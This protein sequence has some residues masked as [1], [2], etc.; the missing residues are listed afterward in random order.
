MLGELMMT[1]KQS[2]IC[3]IAIIGV[4]TG[5]HSSA[6]TRSGSAPRIVLIGGA[7]SHEAG[8]HDFPNGIRMLARFLQSSPSVSECRVLIDSYPDGWPT[9]ADAF[10]N[11]STIVWYFDGLE[12]HPLFDKRRRADFT[13]LMR[14]GVGLVALH[15]SF[16]VP[17]GARTIQLSQWLGGVRYGMFD[18]TTEFVQFGLAPR[19]PITRGVH[20]L[21]YR[22]EFYPTISF[23]DAARRIPILS[24]PLH[25]QYRAGRVIENSPAE[26]Y[27]VAWAFERTDGGRAFAFS[28]LHYLAA[29]D[30]PD[31]RRLLLNAILWTAKQDIPLDG[32]HTD[33]SRDTTTSSSRKDRGTPGE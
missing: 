4:L 27:V 12:Q 8:E 21:E 16:T 26:N 18:R 20:H 29:L 11:A 15:Q 10:A 1:R 31:L 33:G 32:V 7:K 14:K 6:C 17:D 9:T 25:V 5:H 3:L 2:L 22:D 28:G 30:N 23:P 19:H 24:G 13:E